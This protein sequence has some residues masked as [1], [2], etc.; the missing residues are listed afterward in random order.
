[1]IDRTDFTA[2]ELSAATAVGDDEFA[3]DGDAIEPA[4]GWGAEG[5]EDGEFAEDEGAIEPAEEEPDTSAAEDAE[6]D[7]PA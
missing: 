7:A 1:M 4:E 3:E 5:D 6:G 2:E